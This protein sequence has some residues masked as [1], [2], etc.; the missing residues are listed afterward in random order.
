MPGDLLSTAEAS[1][2]LQTSKR[3]VLQLVEVGLL[4][5]AAEVG[6][7]FIFQRADVEKLAGDGWPGRRQRR[8]ESD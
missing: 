7:A 3:R 2:I 8:A 4:P 5:K 1:E 6:G